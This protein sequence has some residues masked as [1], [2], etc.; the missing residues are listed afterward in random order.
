MIERIHDFQLLSRYHAMID[1]IRG[2]PHPKI[3][4][5][6]RS[7]GAAREPGGDVGVFPSSFNPITNGHMAMLQRAIQIKAFKEILLILDTQAMDKEIF[8]ATLIDRILMLQ[9]LFEG[10]LRFSVGVSN[11]GLFLSKANVL[12]EMFPRGTDITFIVGYDTLARVFDP[13]YYEDRQDALDRLFAC[14]TFMVA[15]RGDHG[16]EAVDQLMGVV[17]NRRFKGKVHFF[18]IPVRLAQ[19]AS[20]RVRQRV[21]EGKSYTG[22]VPAPI[23]D[24]IEEVGLYKPDRKVGPQGQGINR[25]GLRTQV[26][27][28]LCDL[29]PG[30]DVE[31]DIGEIVDKA[32]EK[33]R[34]GRSSGTLLDFITERGPVGNGRGRDTLQKIDDKL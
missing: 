10:R 7:K 33:V 5:I 15:N 30:G 13:K 21:M 3:L 14:S 34:N 4:L 19:I 24:F 29:N 11:R 25:Y 6:S 18:E 22:L 8:G 20:S 26:L 28:R 31:I 1:E 2:D 27:W 17:E 23:R 9:A 16:R 12:R 32:V